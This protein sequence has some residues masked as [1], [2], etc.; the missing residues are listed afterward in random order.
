MLLRDAKVAQL[1]FY[2]TNGLDASDDNEAS[3]VE[4]DDE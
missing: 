1:R 4:A 2:T 3:D